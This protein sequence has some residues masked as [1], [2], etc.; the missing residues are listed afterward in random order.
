M[1]SLMKKR[2]VLRPVSCVIHVQSTAV[3]PADPGNVPWCDSNIYYSLKNDTEITRRNC[4][5][6]ALKD[7]FTYTF[8]LF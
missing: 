2:V 5:H 3:T 8:F 7:M 4:Q 1:N 6:E